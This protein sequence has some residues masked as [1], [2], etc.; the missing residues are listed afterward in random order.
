MQQPAQP[1]V[2]ESPAA[3][4]QELIQAPAQEADVPVVPGKLEP[5]DNDVLVV[6]E[7]PLYN[8]IPGP[9]RSRHTT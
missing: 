1:A 9:T 5:L 2:D 8:V 6:L 3:T 4:A 7:L